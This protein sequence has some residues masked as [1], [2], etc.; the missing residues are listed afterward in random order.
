[1]TSL[2]QSPPSILSETNS[3]L[4]ILRDFIFQ[5]NSDLISNSNPKAFGLLPHPYIS[6]GASPLRIPMPT[7]RQNQAPAATRV[8]PTSPLPVV[9]AISILNPPFKL[10]YVS[11]VRS[12]GPNHRKKNHVE[13]RFVS[14]AIYHQSLVIV[15]R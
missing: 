1:M 5:L 13:T 11:V 3:N 2:L 15:S 14:S 6:L 7:P 12:Q 9:A 4:Q 10:N 8:P